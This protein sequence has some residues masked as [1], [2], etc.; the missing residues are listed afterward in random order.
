MFLADPWENYSG[1][2]VFAAL[3]FLFGIGL[4]A[5]IP[6]YLL[7]HIYQYYH[8][9]NKLQKSLFAI[10]AVLP[11][12]ALA[13]YLPV[14]GKNYRSFEESVNANSV[15]TLAPNYF[16]E[17]LMGIGFKYHTKL[18]YLNDG[19]RPPLHDPF[20]N[21]GLWVYADSYYPFS[22]L[23]RQGYYKLLFP[24]LKLRTRCPCSYSYDGMGYF[25]E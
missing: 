9:A 4:L 20:L 21:M 13:V 15:E 11:F 17:R 6:F 8:A 16:S 14:F 7:W 2:L 18:E 24:N 10:G 1:Y 5:F 23:K 19:W 22:S 25:R 12:L 3:I